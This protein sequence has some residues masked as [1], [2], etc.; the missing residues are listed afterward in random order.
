MDI[1]FYKMST[2]NGGAPC[3]YNGL[4]SLAICKPRIRSTAGKGALIFGFAAKSIDPDNG[5]IHVARVSDRIEHGKYYETSEFQE[6]PDC[7]Y[8]LSGGIWEWVRENG[9]HESREDMDRD[10]GQKREHAH[11]LLSDDFRYF[12]GNR[13]A[14]DRARFPLVRDA[15]DS[16]TQGHRRWHSS[17]LYAEL[18]ELADRLFESDTEIGQP[19][20]RGRC[21]CNVDDDEPEG[22]CGR[23]SGD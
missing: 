3:V 4:W 20:D 8:R 14:V 2:D 6:R 10:L 15:L 23:N 16:L 9:F 21:R 22:V 17:A 5:V 18:S 13:F 12:G 1:Y 19:T 11:A 7:I